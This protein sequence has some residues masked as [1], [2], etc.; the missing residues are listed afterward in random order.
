MSTGDDFTMTP[1]V[2]EKVASVAQRH[3]RHLTTPDIG[4][5]RFGI[6]GGGKV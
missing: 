3:L 6:M 5:G 4:V 1:G 2:H